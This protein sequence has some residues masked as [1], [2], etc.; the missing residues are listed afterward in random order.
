MQP[1]IRTWLPVIVYCTAIFVQSSYPTPDEIP[2]FAASDKLL[3]VL[4]YGILGA[5]VCRA[6]NTVG[7]WR[8]RWGMLIC[9]GVVAATM[10]G[11]SDEWHQSCVAGRSAEFTDLIAD[12]VGSIA[13]SITYVWFLHI[14]W[15]STLT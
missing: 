5:L 8:H 10:Y 13:G 15:K 6:A 2:H 1:F 12:F 9:I 14:R 7:R 4:A 3:H 11:A